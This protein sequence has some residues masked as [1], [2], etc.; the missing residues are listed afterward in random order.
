MCQGEISRTDIRR[1]G[2][3]G[4]TLA[5]RRPHKTT[6]A[7]KEQRKSGEKG[8]KDLLLLLLLSLNGRPVMK[9]SCPMLTKINH[10][11]SHSHTHT[12]SGVHVQE[13]E[14][15]MKVKKCRSNSAANVR[16]RAMRE[17]S[18]P[19]PSP[20]NVHESRVPVDL[21]DGCCMIQVNGGRERRS[22]CGFWP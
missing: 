21:I 11:L 19:S 9:H 16:E 13:Y 10:T 2:R 5:S 12:R 17:G 18:P 6:T 22:L 4:V 15:K 3:T 14:K 1:S 20:A 8:A 7:Q